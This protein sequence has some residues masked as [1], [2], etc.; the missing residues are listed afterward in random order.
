MTQPITD[1][2]LRTDDRFPTQVEVS[3]RPYT[4]CGNLRWTQAVMH[5]FS[6]QGAYLE[7]DLDCAPGTILIVRTV[8]W[9]AAPSAADNLAKPPSICL[10]EIKWR[11]DLLDEGGC[12]F[13]M[14]L[15]FF[16]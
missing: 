10:G 11:Q 15:R 3:C 6:S 2:E 12:C 14:G 16:D 1:A 4:S 8:A 9:L 5:N 7:T 13:G